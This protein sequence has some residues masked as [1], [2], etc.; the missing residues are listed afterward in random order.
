MGY[1]IS[2][3]L[4]FLIAF[5]FHRGLGEADAMRKDMKESYRRRGAIMHPRPGSSMS[6][7]ELGAL[8]EQAIEWLG[9]GIRSAITCGYTRDIP[10]QI[11]AAIFDKA[12]PS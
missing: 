8:A 12:L 6:E 5:V 4:S 7:K 11:D 2:N 1:A 9:Q 10:Q 3:R